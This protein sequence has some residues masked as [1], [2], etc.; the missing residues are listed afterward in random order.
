MTIKAISLWQPW[1]SLIA[2]GAKH[3]ETRHWWTRYR[4]PLVIHAAKNTKGLDIIDDLDDEVQQLIY[5][6]MSAAGYESLQQLPLG[7]FLCR[8][9]LTRCVPAVTA[10]ELHPDQW[11]YGDYSPGRYGWLLDDINAF[12]SPISARGQ[13]GLWNVEIEESAA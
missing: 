5:A 12:E 7:A 4:G 10:L 2:F 13:Q 3:I 6:A 11:P 9:T 1:A 8:C